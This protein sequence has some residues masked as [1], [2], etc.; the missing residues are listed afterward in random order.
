MY[1][2][3]LILIFYITKILGH[4]FFSLYIFLGERLKI[5]IKKINTITVKTIEIM[6]L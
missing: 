4:V 3:I 1:L 5:Y 2:R 6:K